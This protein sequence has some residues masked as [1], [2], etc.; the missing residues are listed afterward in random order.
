M[1]VE[2]AA[3]YDLRDIVLQEASGGDQDLGTLS[4]P[5]QQHHLQQL[6]QQH[7]QRLQQQQ[8]QLLHQQPQQQRAQRM[9]VCRV[10]QRGFRHATDYRRHVLSK[11]SLS[12]PR[13]VCEQCG[14]A[15]KWDNSLMRHRRTCRGAR[16][17]Q[18]QQE[19]HPQQKDQQ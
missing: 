10:C 8:L 12:P 17:G 7:H 13:H 19:G 18:Q 5:H 15:Y 1:G 4:N 2:F 6:R 14:A 11:H 3:Q 16:G 9:M